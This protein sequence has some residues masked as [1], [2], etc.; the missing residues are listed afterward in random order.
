[1]NAEREMYQELLSE[2]ED[3]LALLAQQDCEKKFLQ[4]ALAEL[5]GNDAIE[6]AIHQAE[7]TLL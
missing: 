6:K 5:G 1:M 7:A 3:L 4:Q 2:H